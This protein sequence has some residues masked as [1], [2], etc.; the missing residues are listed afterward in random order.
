M[1]IVEF[2]EGREAIGP[3]W[4]FKIKYTSREIQGQKQGIDFDETFSPAVCFPSIRVLLAFG[5]QNDN[6]YTFIRWT[7]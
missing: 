3:K 4:V 6:M 1:G 7:Y 2:P 5:V